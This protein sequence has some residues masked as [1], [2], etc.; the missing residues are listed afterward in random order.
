MAYMS[1]F[2][3]NIQWVFTTHA[4]AVNIMIGLKHTRSRRLILH[5]SWLIP[6]IDV[7]LCRHMGPVCHGGDVYK[8][9]YPQ[10]NRRHDRV[11]KYTVHTRTTRQ[12]EMANTSPRHMPVLGN[13]HP[14][15]IENFDIF[16]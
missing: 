5:F 13:V 1:A 6:V 3:W 2:S 16:S 9:Q 11:S 8:K 12:S 14:I 10:Y 4:Y 15:K 7:I